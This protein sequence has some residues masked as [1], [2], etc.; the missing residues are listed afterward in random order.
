MICPDCNGLAEQVI[1][2]Q[3]RPRRITCLRCL[4]KGVVPEEMA[5]WIRAGRLLRHS[6][7]NGVEYRTLLEE[8]HRRGL[9][10]VTLS[11]MEMGKIKPV[12]PTE[13]SGAQ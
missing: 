2:V 8:A 11:K 13:A 1:F 3:C 5:D 4:G 7:V 9:D 12:F 10:V 6:R